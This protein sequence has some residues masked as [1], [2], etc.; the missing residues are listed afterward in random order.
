VSEGRCSSVVRVSRWVLLWAVLFCVV[1]G[2]VVASEAA[3]IFP[4]NGSLNGPKPGEGF[5][6]LDAESVA[7]NGFNHHVLVADSGVGKVYDFVSASDTSPGVWDGLNTPAKSFGSGR[8]SVAVDDATGDVYVAD[9]S[10]RVVD[11]FDGSGKLVEGFGVKG[12]IAGTPSELFLPPIPTPFGQGTFGITVNQATGELYVIDALHKVVDVFESSGKYV[13]QNVEA[14]GELYG[15]GE[16]A[17]FKVPE[18]DFTDGLAVN[19]FDGRVLVSDSW[20]LKAYRFG[21]SGGFIEPAIGPFGSLFTS[22]AAHNSTGRVFIADGSHEVVDAFKAGKEEGAPAGHISGTPGPSNN[23]VAVDQATGEVYVSDNN[24]LSVKIFTPAV[25]PNVE[26][27][28]ASA[29]QPT[30]ATFNGT[31][32]TENAGNATCQFVWGTTEA[33]GHTAPCEP[34]EVP[35]GNGIVGVHADVSGLERDTTYYYR[36]EATNSNGTNNGAETETRQL[37]TPGA[38][39]GEEAVVGVSAESAT[40]QARIDPNNARTVYRFE[41]GTTGGYGGSVPGLPGAVLSGGKGGMGVVQHV[42]GLSAGTVYHYRLVVLSELVGGVFTEFAGPDHTFLTQA[43]GQAGG[44]GTVLPDGRAWELV[45]PP[46]KHGARI[47][48]INEIS[49]VQASVGGDAITYVASAPV[50]SEPRGNTSLPQVFSGRGAGGWVS[51]TI[52]VPHETSFGS[53]QGLGSEYRFFSEDLS[54]GVVQPFGGFPVSGSASSLSGEASEQ[55]AFLRTNF[56]GGDVSQQ[57]VG[58]CYRPLVSG[59]P[60]YANVPVGTVFGVHGPEHATC[61]PEVTCG[62][63]F[64]GASP[65]GSHVVLVSEVGLTVGTSGGLYE[66]AGGVLTFV[67]HGE[68]HL[69]SGDGSRVVFSGSGEGLEGL[70]MRDGSGMVQLDAAEPGCLSCGGGGGSYRGGSVD[71]SKVFF[72]DTERLTGNAGASVNEPDLYECEMVVVA[73]RSRCVLSDLTPVGAG[74]EHANVAQE[75]SGGLLGGGVLGVSSDGSWVYFAAGGKLAAGGQE[76]ATCEGVFGSV[77]N[78]YVRH[79]GVTRLVAVVS[80]EDYPDWAGALLYHTARVSSGGGWLAFMSERSLTGYDNRDAV[81]GLPDEEVYLYDGSTGV[82]VCASCNPSGARPTGTEYGRLKLAGRVRNWPSSQG[83][84]ANIPGWTS[85]VSDSSTAQALHQ[86]RFLSDG[87]RLFFDSGDALVAGDVDGTEDVYEFEPVGVGSCVVG[88]VGFV[89]GS[90]G[91]VGLVSSGGG[92]GEESVFLDAS[93]SGGDVFFLTS[94]RLSSADFDSSADVYDAHECSG[95]SPCVSVPVVPPACLTADACRAT[96][97]LQP[98]I[99]GA[100]SSATFSG[101]GNVGS[102]SSSSRGGRSVAQM[103]AERLV[104]ALRVCGRVPRRR[105][106]LCVRRARRAYGPVSRKTGVRKTGVRVM[107]SSS[108]KRGG[109]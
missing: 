8:V 101:V 61:P 65:D 73:G 35:N 30:S 47:V 63:R 43:Q 24:S 38:G 6:H 109:K 59:A 34:V 78:L 31:V 40:F 50:E 76:H 48:A 72:T 1:P 66:W 77:C 16:L 97:L 88:G 22:V 106:A 105:R 23:G 93:E 19:D 2:G 95:V 39:F 83:I 13:R 71:G 90:G 87:G 27:G 85:Y 14:P 10:D 82:L 53:G 52:A 54:V 55:T 99:F 26:T 69:V 89:G 32:E 49:L 91:C 37:I 56:V 21:L 81:S 84:A 68:T 96:P 104:R 58:S 74:G 79:G 92:S 98:S 62:P 12:A 41:Y 18:G 108:V 102:L 94:A 3:L 20:D 11:K 4:G 5:S 107:G 7:A 86:S 70:L 44:G 15:G 67:G 103:R 42:Q 33:F 60:G 45:S 100:P 80:G 36:L 25:V 28:Q 51:H 75:S 64:S 46:D 57:C 17:G 29:L 9:A